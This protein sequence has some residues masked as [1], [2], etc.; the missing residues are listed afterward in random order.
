MHDLEA[1]S[2]QPFPSPPQ[3]TPEHPPLQPITKPSKLPT[4]PAELLAEIMDHVGDW[5]LAKAVGVV[6]SIKRPKEWDSASSADLSALL[7]TTNFNPTGLT[8]I[9]A[10][11]IVRLSYTNILTYIR[12]RDFAIFNALYTGIH[13][14]LIPF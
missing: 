14:L 6:T 9:G 5:E 1:Y 7:S 4:L 13:P 10:N 3:V 11:A 8:S 2:I 12:I